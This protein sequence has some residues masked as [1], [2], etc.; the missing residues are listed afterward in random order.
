MFPISVEQKISLVKSSQKLDNFDVI[1]LNI[2]RC[3]YMC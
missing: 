2:C 1:I 3:A